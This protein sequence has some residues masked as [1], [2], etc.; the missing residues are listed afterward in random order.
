MNPH[1]AAARLPCT[2][3]VRRHSRWQGVIVFIVICWLDQACRRRVLRDQASWLERPENSEALRL[4]EEQAA[5]SLQFAVV[6]SMVSRMRPKDAEQNKCPPRR[7]AR[8]VHHDFIRVDGHNRL[9]IRANV[10]TASASCRW[11][12]SCRSRGFID[13]GAHRHY[14]ERCRKRKAQHNIG[15]QINR[16][17]GADLGAWRC[18]V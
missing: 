1:F 18:G 2:F 15:R 16:A 17:V 10:A 3:R 5:A 7:P 12:R 6:G 9:A 11:P 13:I 8:S 14:S 4:G